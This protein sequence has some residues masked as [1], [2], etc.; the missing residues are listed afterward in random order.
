M[1][2]NILIDTSIL[3]Q[4][5]SPIEFN[6]YLDQLIKWE[7]QDDVII[8]CPATLKKE[9][10]KHRVEEF[11]K[12]DQAL[13]NHL[14][15]LKTSKLFLK[16]PD[17]GEAELTAAD[18]MLRSQVEAID[19]LLEKAIYISDENA[20]AGKMW[21]QKQAK[22]APFRRKEASDNDAVILFAVLEVISTAVQPELFFLSANH[23]DYA[24]PGNEDVIHADIVG[25]YPGINIIYYTS[26]STAIS[27]LTN[28]GLPSARH[29]A[30]NGKGPVPEL[31]P[32][33]RSKV[34]IDQLYDYLNKRF[35]D[36]RL[37]PKKLFCIHY[38]IITE[39]AYDDRGRPFTM[40]TDNQELY[41]LFA[42]LQT[43]GQVYIGEE[44]P[45]R[46]GNRPIF[47]LLQV[48]RS[49]YVHAITLRGGRPL[50]LPIVETTACTCSVCT[51]HRAEFGE[52]IKQLTALTTEPTSTLKKAFTFYLHGQLT[53]AVTVLKEV[54]ADAEKDRKWL[55][56]YLANYNLSLLGHLLRFRYHSPETADQLSTELRSIKMDDVY[57][58]SKETSQCS[59]LNYLH[60]GA[61]L[62]EATSEMKRLSQKIKEYHIDQNGGW[63]DD[64]RSMLDLYFETVSFIEQ[65]Y[66]MID[67]FSNINTFTNCFVEGL[68]ASYTCKNTLGGKLLHF[69][70]PIIEKIVAYAKTD[71]LIKYRQ[72]YDIKVAKYERNGTGTFIPQFC[73][74]LENYSVL[75]AQFSDG[76]LEGAESI[77]PR[78][79]RMFG[80][81]LTI[82]G[83]LELTTKEVATICKHL[84]PFLKAQ[85]HLHEY[86]LSTS[87]AY[88]IRNN[89]PQI[90][91]AVLQEFLHFAFTYKTTFGHQLV[92]VFYHISL[93]RELKLQLTEHEWHDIQ[94]V[95]L[96]NDTLDKNHD[97]IDE[98][99]SL[100]RYVAESKRKNEIS[101]FLLYNLYHQFKGQ[102]YYWAVINDMVKPK[103]QLTNKYENEII[104]LAEKGQQPRIFESG[105]YTDYRLDEYLNFCFRYKR[106]LSAQL[107]EALQKLDDYYCWITDIEEFDYSQFD[108]DWLFVHMTIYYKQKFRASKALKNYLREQVM[109][110]KDHRLGQLFIDLYVPTTKK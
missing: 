82:A 20:A 103:R 32:I 64:T 13:K 65:N 57:R 79:R 102:I 68:F 50:D 18:K 52:S 110:S 77:W 4:L 62:D 109:R 66:I 26:L 56:Y 16:T 33:D 39:A 83:I 61:F 48:L 29:I 28:L 5:V 80:N 9:W 2:K 43:D 97:L 37:L 108:D 17:I 42:G 38:P 47:N 23:T 59:I 8:Y 90:D 71:E 75:S 21:M 78:Y 34:L 89:A 86:E 36:I 31:I 1:A 106:V 12:I 49:N 69:T 58:V 92:N 91:I 81:S 67:E 22:K 55:T 93:T 87:L 25:L 100:H 45:D 10:L 6:G 35:S 27:S 44:V 72:R 94:S 11:K 40:N 76:N 19:R 63:T 107:V 60:K 15:N 53:V 30:K 7:N 70:D 95:Y 24:A 98:I 88:F 74:M 85:K 99:C 54:A 84:M 3:K 14:K 46:N 104:Q 101:A 96:V 41:E 73:N 105:F 51:F